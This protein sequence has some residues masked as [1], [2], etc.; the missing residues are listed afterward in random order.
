MNEYMTITK[1]IDLTH[2]EL[3]T[4]ADALIEMTRKEEREAQIIGRKVDRDRIDRLFDL[5]DKIWETLEAPAGSADDQD[6]IDGLLTVSQA[7]TLWDLNS[8][9]IRRAIMDGR[10]KQNLDCLKFG[11][12]WAVSRAAMTR[13]YGECKHPLWEGL[14]EEEMAAAI[15]AKDVR[16][17]QRIYN[18]TMLENCSGDML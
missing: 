14:S 11:K 13:L 6:P 17:E 8:S 1:T 9:T 16:E 15:V 12:Q 18:E 5:H 7:A 3:L 4:I 2:K 10:L